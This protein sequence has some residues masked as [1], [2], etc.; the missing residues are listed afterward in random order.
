[1]NIYHKLSLL[2]SVFVLAAAPFFVDAASVYLSPSSGSY[3]VGDQFTV[4]ILASGSGQEINAVNATIIPKN[5]NLQIVSASKS[6]SILDFWTVEPKVQSNGSIQLEG[7]ML[8]KGYSGSA[9]KI[10]TATVRARSEGQSGL[11]VTSAEV[12][13]N[14][15]LGTKLATTLGTAN[16]SV[17]PRPIVEDKIVE[18][19]EPSDDF[20]FEKNIR[21]GDENEDVRMLQICLENQGFF[22]DSITEFFGEVTKDAVTEF[23][24]EYQ[25]NEEGEVLKETRQKLN[26][27]CFGIV[28][29]DEEVTPS[30]DQELEDDDQ[31]VYTDIS[32]WIKAT[33][34]FA[35]MNFILL[36]FIILLVLRKTSCRC[37]RKEDAILKKERSSLLRL[38]RNL[39]D[40]HSQVQQTLVSVDEKIEKTSKKKEPV[41]KKDL[42]E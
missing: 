14:D 8:G 33:I 3:S 38:R 9:A 40:V 39:K 1:M 37:G 7:V 19:E 29:V 13:A 5:S 27:R 23:Q 16:F 30:V 26:E 35:G 4:D 18:I 36:I 42:T 6:G 11:S 32:F 10:A 31:V 21:Q 15:G 12:L 17:N 34:A 20:L 28:I 2:L 25:I 24:Q 22:Q 41:K